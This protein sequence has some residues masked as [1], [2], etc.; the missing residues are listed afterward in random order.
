MNPVAHPLSDGSQLVA[1]RSSSRKPSRAA[2]IPQSVAA[3]EVPFVSSSAAHESGASAAPLH[4]DP[5]LSS[6]LAMGIVR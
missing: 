2:P 6:Q 1:G 3:F 4:E 5:C